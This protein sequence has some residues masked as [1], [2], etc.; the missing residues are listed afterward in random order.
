MTPVLGPRCPHLE[1]GLRR[2]LSPGAAEAGATNGTAPGQ[3]ELI[4]PIQRWEVRSQGSAGTRAPGAAGAPLPPPGLQVAP[5]LHG[6]GCHLARSVP[7]L[8]L[9]S[10]RFRAPLLWHAHPGR[11]QGS[12]F[13]GRPH[14]WAQDWDVDPPCG[15]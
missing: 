5:V 4:V 3:E 9:P 10:P 12:S 2:F 15:A 13:P 11:L 8:T 1:T 6:G 14:P 7:L